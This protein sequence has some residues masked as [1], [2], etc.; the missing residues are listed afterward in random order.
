MKFWQTIHRGYQLKM[1]PY[2]QPW[3]LSPEEQSDERY[4]GLLLDGVIAEITVPPLVT[5]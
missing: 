4:D 1:G 3:P 2:S 5:F